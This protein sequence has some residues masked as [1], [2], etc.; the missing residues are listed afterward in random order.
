MDEIGVQGCINFFRDGDMD[1]FGVMCN[2]KVV[3]VFISE[4][5]SASLCFDFI[6]FII[7]I[8]VYGI[9]IDLYIVG[10]DLFVFGFIICTI[11]YVVSV[12]IVVVEIV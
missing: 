1:S 7:V 5:V 12:H 4:K 10:V 3:C 8:V 11:F 6:C 2:T 9:V